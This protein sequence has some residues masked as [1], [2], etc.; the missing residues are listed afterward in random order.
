MNVS[1]YLPDE[2]RV[3]GNALI[4]NQKWQKWQ[5]WDVC[6]DGKDGKF[7]AAPAALFIPSSFIA[8][9]DSS[10]FHKTSRVHVMNRTDLAYILCWHVDMYI[11]RTLWRAEFVIL[12]TLF[13]AM[14]SVFMCFFS[15]EGGTVRVIGEHNEKDQVY[16]VTQKR[17]TAFSIYVWRLAKDN[18]LTWC[19]LVI[20]KVPVTF[21]GTPCM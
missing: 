8:I 18:D 7:L 15:V 13:N 16:R 3:T 10:F 20:K 14:G 4:N 11:C 17:G 2:L 5:R 19:W 12:A 21:F 1:E 9:D 6:G